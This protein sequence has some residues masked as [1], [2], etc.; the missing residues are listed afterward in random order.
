[1]KKYDIRIVIDRLLHEIEEEDIGISLFSICYQNQSELKFF[2]NEDREKVAKIF[3]KISE[4]SKRHKEI[5]E[6]IITH[7]GEKCLCEMNI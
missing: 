4:D 1:M 5:I 2:K 7:L 3:K 6:K